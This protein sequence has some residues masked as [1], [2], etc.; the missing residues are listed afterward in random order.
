MYTN[1]KCKQYV[2][3]LR[4]FTSDNFW[5]IC[6]LTNAVSCTV[7]NCHNSCCCC[8]CFSDVLS[9]WLILLILFTCNSQWALSPALCAC[10]F[11]PHLPSNYVLFIY[12]NYTL[13][14][15]HAHHVCKS[16]QH[17]VMSVTYLFPPI[18][19]EVCKYI[20]LGCHQHHH[21]N[22]TEIETLVTFTHHIPGQGDIHTDHI[23]PHFMTFTCLPSLQLI[24]VRGRGGESV[25]MCG[26]TACIFPP[27]YAQGSQ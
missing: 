25:C 13:H 16:L 4:L 18:T 1:T 27:H 7:N 17:A 12:S 14:F 6:H 26:E 19:V 23:F 2:I 11:K 20:S 3:N 8:C 24:W 9:I 5:L 10:M 22:T 21:K 15:A